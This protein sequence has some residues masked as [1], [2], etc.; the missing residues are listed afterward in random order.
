MKKAA[1]SLFLVCGLALSACGT[2]F[3]EEPANIEVEEVG[4]NHTLPESFYRQSM[5][6]LKL[7][8]PNADYR[9]TAPRIPYGDLAYSYIEYKPTPEKNNMMHMHALITDGER[10][11]R[12]D[13]KF[14]VG[15]R[16]KYRTRFNAILE[17]IQR[18][19][20]PEFIRNNF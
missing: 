5:A 8:Y 7:Q 13:E 4:Y 10:A 6:V 20:N 17:N 11:W 2:P 1:L 15:E 19:R 3:K 18:A 12:I 9:S 16:L 14:E